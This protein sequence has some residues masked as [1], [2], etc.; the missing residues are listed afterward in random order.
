LDIDELEEF[1]KLPLED[2]KNCDPIQWWAG[3]R[4]QFPNLSRFA[5][6][7]LSIPGMSFVLIE[8]HSTD[9]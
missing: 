6:D 1:F 2:F 7:I 4:T 9:T 5:R 3:R 8:D